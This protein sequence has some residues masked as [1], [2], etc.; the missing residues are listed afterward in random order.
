MTSLLI[1]I[2]PLCE[3]G[4]NHGLEEMHKALS[5]PSEADI[6]RPHES[7]FIR[8]LIERATAKGITTLDALHA[9]L[10]GWMVRGYVGPPSPKPAGTMIHWTPEEMWGAD[11]Y[12]SGIPQSLW[13]ADDY[14]LLVDYLVQKHLPGSFAM[15]Q[16]GYMV[17]RGLLMGT[18]E[19]AVG[20]ITIKRAA[21]IL[22]AVEG[23]AEIDAAM[24]LAMIDNATIDFGRA[25]CAESITALTDSARHKMKGVILDYAETIKVGGKPMHSSMQQKLLDNFGEL[26]RDWRR[27]AATET[28]N[29]ALG[30]FIAAMPDGAKVKRVE[31]YQGACPFCRKINGIVLEVVDAASDSK[32]WDKQVWVGKTN[33]GRSASPLKRVGGQLVKRE[34][35]E[36]WTVPA[37]T[38]HPHC[39]GRW[40]KMSDTAPADNLTLWLDGFKEE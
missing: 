25:R 15:S 35:D 36:L 26:N 33:R 21:D 7:E 3:C 4:S 34:D 1:D 29:M 28:S 40:V 12:L 13:T 5:T 14:V 30:G 2:G 19:A 8:D 24:R 22:A 23:Q 27:I 6:W 17:K 16:S 39:R 37:D 18:V 32:D 31:Q 10:V 20:A 11:A 9:D 38:A